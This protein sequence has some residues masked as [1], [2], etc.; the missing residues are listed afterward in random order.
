MGVVAG[1]IYLTSTKLYVCYCLW[2]STGITA[3]NREMYK[4]YIQKKG[5]DRW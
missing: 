2:L 5:K 1:R 3:V 4:H